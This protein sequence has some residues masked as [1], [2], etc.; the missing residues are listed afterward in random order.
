MGDPVDLVEH[1]NLVRFT[2]VETLKHPDHDLAL[3]LPIRMG[4]VDHVHQHIGLSRFLKRG[5]E[6][7]HQVV[8]K[9]A[10]KP[11]RIGY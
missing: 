9:L 11:N 8:R 3:F 6:R 1:Q 10:D 2:K 5:P 7:G 4:C